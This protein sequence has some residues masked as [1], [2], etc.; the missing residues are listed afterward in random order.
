MAATVAV[1]DISGTAAVDH[2]RSLQEFTVGTRKSE[3]ALKQTDMVLKALLAVRPEYR[4]QVRQE[5][6]QLATSTK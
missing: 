3:L 2:E 6:P 1:P 4:Y 5:I